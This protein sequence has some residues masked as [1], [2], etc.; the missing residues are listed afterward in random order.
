MGMT[1]YENAERKFFKVDTAVS[2][3]HLLLDDK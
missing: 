2:S 1:I 3:L